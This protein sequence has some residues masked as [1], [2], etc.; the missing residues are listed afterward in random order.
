MGYK[1]TPNLTHISL[2][3]TDKIASILQNVA[4]ILSTVKG[5]C[6]MYRQFGITGDFVDKPIP[7]AQVLM[8]SD[9]KEAIETYEPRVEVIGVE[10]HVSVAEPGKLLPTVTVEVISDE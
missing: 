5:T 10:F 6:P 7:V 4:I 3:E 8:Q 9:I 1:V 2:N